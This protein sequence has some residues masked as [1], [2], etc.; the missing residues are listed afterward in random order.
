MNVDHIDHRPDNGETVLLFQDDFS[1]YDVAETIYKIPFQDDLHLGPWRLSSLHYIWT[2]KRFSNWTETGFPWAIGD[3]GGLRYIEMPETLMNVV[4][5]AGEEDWRNYA[6]ELRVAWMGEGTIGPLFRYRTSR[7]TYR[8][9]FVEGKKLRIV[10]R[11]DTK[12]IVLA[13][14]DYPH[15]A[16]D[17]YPV[18]IRLQGPRIRVFIDRELVFDIEDDTYLSGRIG[19]RTEGTGRFAQV[20]VAAHRA[21]HSDLVYRSVLRTHR[22]NERA[23]RYPKCV[24]QRTVHLPRAFSFVHAVDVE[25]DGK[26]EYVGF[27]AD[28]WRDDYTHIAGLGVYDEDGREM[29]YQGHP[30]TSDRPMHSDVAYQIGDL[31]GDGMKEILYTQDFQMKMVHALTGEVIRSAPT[32]EAIRGCED[33]FPRIVGD[34][35]HICTLRGAG[36][37]RDF[38]IKDRYCNIWAYT[39]DFERLWHRQLNTGH[40]PRAADINGDGRDEVMAGYSMLDAGGNTLWTVPNSDPLRNYYPGP[41]HA[42][43]LWIGKFKEGEDA[44]IEIAIAAS[45]LGLNLLDVD[46]NLL[47]RDLC[48]HAQSLGI[49]KFRRDLPG[50]Q[51]L[52][53]DFWGNMGIAVLFDC[54]GNRLTTKEFDYFPEPI[55]VK[56]DLTGE[57]LFYGG[58]LSTAL[59]DGYMNPVVTIPRGEGMR[60]SFMDVD[61]DGL[62]EFL[63]LEG[64]RIHIWGRERILGAQ[65]ILDER[66]FEN[67]NGYGGFYL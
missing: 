39:S 14:R 65:D 15:C 57:A 48:G 43:S 20:R 34:S 36:Y 63:F 2:S 66:T 50:R 56:W 17:W 61:G 5:A 28:V 52:V 21:E 26:M 25:G 55:P 29:W 22:L 42:D 30:R 35:F 3:D 8:L 60:P 38:L 33:A 23:G 62:D 18:E 1:S 67:F 27:L 40:Y 24:H 7:H 9:D 10:L 54:C 13:E 58:G 46:G 64:K 41:E 6:F 59:I 11:N 31:N 45:D 51:F 53:V 49:A 16:S 19:L 12:E 44:P 37:G 47:A 32:P 4:L